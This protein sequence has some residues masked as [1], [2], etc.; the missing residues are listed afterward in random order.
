[1]DAGEIGSGHTVTAFYEMELAEELNA[2]RLALCL[3]RYKEPD[4]DVGIELG[5]DIFAEDMAD[6]FSGA[7]PSFRFAA[8]V[9]EFAE[10]LRISKHSEGA[11]FSDILGVVAES[12]NPEH[13]EEPEFL[14]LVQKAA[15]LWPTD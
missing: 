3:M 9:V 10:I 6:H 1:V 11:R 14:E 8:A 2:E 4:G 15:D 13:P 7:S 12:L 5:R